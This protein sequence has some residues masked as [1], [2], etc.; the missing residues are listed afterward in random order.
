MNIRLLKPKNYEY[1]STKFTCFIDFLYNFIGVSLPLFW[2]LFPF[3]YSI[4]QNEVLN[5]R[6]FVNSSLPDYYG[7]YYFFLTQIS[8]QMLLKIHKVYI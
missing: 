8:T 1:C 6:V 2:T 4:T 7:D 3:A 5:W